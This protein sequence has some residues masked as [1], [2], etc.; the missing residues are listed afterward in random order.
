MDQKELGL[1][2]DTLFVPMLG[3]IY[4]SENFP[5]ILYDKKALELKVWLPKQIMDHDAQTQYTYL[6]SASRSANMDHHILD[7]LKRNPDG[8]IVQL[9]V[10]LETTFY[11]DDNG[12]TQWYAVDLPHVISYRRTLLPEMT[13]ETYLSGNAFSKAWLQ[14][15]RKKHPDAPLLITASGFFYYFKEE[16]VLSFIH[17]LQN[18]GNI[19]LL[20]D[21]VN[22]SGLMMMNMKYMK[23][24]GHGEVPMYFY[25][26]SAQ[27]LA[28]KVGDG[29][30]VLFEE[31]FYQNIP[32]SG[33][34]FS[35]KMTMHFADWLHMVKMIQLQIKS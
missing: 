25:V 18:H 7:F 13:R 12:H 5:S 4:A 32:K 20:F 33:L 26:D 19:E 29:V 31:G 24:V 1:I 23:T 17:M 34:S 15:I 8:V 6:A 21:A 22:K 14:D 16:K 3:R 11:R 30:S 28:K 27:K 35:T 10:G 2:E 9:G